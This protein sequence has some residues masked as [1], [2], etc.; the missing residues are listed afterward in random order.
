MKVAY[1]FILCLLKTG[2]GFSPENMKFYVYYSLD[3][4][5]Q[6][7]PRKI[8]LPKQNTEKRL[9]N[10]VIWKEGHAIGAVAFF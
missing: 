3:Q 1:D 8:I 4:Y 7:E 2:G 9:N 5:Y 10:K 6:R